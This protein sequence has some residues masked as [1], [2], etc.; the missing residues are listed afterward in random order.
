MRRLASLVRWFFG[1]R[2][3]R[4]IDDDPSLP[5]APEEFG[6]LIRS[7]KREDMK[8]LAEGLACR[9]IPHRIKYRATH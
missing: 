8:R 2:M 7:G 5:F 6:R 4:P 9:S 3:R 1:P